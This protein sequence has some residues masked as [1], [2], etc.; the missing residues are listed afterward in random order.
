MGPINARTWLA[1]KKDSTGKGMASVSNDRMVF[2]A[3]HSSTML[4][5][6][7]FLRSVDQ[8]FQALS[9]DWPEYQLKKLVDMVVA[10]PP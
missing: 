9:I 7:C 4:W 3:G 10:D 2:M 8:L 1:R 5:S 6:E